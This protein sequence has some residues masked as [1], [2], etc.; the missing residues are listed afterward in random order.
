MNLLER[1]GVYLNEGTIVISVSYIFTGL[2]LIAISIP[3]VRG[4][5]KMNPLYG[6]RIK[7][8]FES[9]E[10]WYKIN[11]YGGRRL[12]FWSIVLICICIASLFFEISEDSILFIAFSLA[13]VIVLIPCLIEIFIYARKL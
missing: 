3:L 12:I 9:E 2:L 7:K 1:G 5:I 8:A 11:K 10:N 13:P 4:S 6:V